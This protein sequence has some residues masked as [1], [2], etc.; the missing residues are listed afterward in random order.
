MGD[1]QL[2]ATGIVL[3]VGVKREQPALADITRAHTG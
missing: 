2:S 3:D 1:G